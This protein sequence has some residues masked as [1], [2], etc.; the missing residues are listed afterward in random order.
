MIPLTEKE[1]KEKLTN[2]S[3]KDLVCSARYLFDRIVVL[4]S[5]S[6]TNL[7]EYPLFLEELERRGIEYWLSFHTD[8][9]EV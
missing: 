3:D 4:E 9:E 1:T 8:I 6:T 5:Y 7:M 2:L